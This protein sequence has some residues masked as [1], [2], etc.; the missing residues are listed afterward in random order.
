MFWGSPGTEVLAER[1]IAGL[2]P[3]R[4]L[5]KMAFIVEAGLRKIPDGLIPTSK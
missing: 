3:I 4:E 5:T 1:G 2:T